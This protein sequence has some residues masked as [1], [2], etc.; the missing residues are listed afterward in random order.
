MFPFSAHLMKLLKLDLFPRASM[1]FFY[2][3]IKKFKDEHCGD[4]SVGVFFILRNAD[5]FQKLCLWVKCEAA[6]SS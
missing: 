4:K 5:S 1:D 3:I 6:A 2:N